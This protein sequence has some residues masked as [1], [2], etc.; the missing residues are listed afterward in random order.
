MALSVGGIIGS[1]EVSNWYTSINSTIKNYGN[2][3]S[4]LSNPISAGRGVMVSDVNNLVSKLN[5][6]KKDSYLQYASYGSYTTVSKGQI[7][8]A[9]DWTGINSSISSL[10]N[11]KCRNTISY[12]NGTYETT[13][14]NGSCKKGCDGNGTDG[15]AGNRANTCTNG[16]YTNSTNS[17]GTNSAGTNTKGSKIDIWCANQSY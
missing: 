14:N 4:Q 17:Q 16:W 9:S 8:K 5:E 12:K 6:L 10:A 7:I 2:G 11:V 13:N 1:S 3:I 15:H